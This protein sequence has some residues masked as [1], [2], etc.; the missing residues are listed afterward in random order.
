MRTSKLNYN[1][2]NYTHFLFTYVQI[3]LKEQHMFLKWSK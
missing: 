3:D 2:N 1:Y